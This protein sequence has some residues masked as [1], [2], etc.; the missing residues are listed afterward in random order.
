MTTFFTNRWKETVGG[1]HLKPYSWRRAIVDS[2]LKP[3]TKHT[4][5]TLSIYMNE[6]GQ[7]CFPGYELIAQQTGAA[8]STVIKHVGVAVAAGFLVKTQ[9]LRENGSNTSNEY[10]PAIP[11]D[12]FTVRQTDGGGVADGLGVVRETDPHNNPLSNNPLE[13]KPDVKKPSTIFDDFWHHFPKTRAGSKEK[14][15][16]ALYK[17][18]ERATTEEIM[19][20]VVAYKNS[21]EVARGFAKGGA[22]W[23]NDDRWASDYRIASGT[24]QTENP[25]MPA[26]MT[27][28]MTPEEIK[29]EKRRRAE[30][31]MG[32]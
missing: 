8:R 24:T 16:A 12:L 28:T 23:L 30:A 31:A 18:L 6:A 32:A 7:T 26:R 21:D 17:A 10:A 29:R 20:G 13:V 3:F 15:A 5:L 27:A 25:T 22:A 1:F 2:S 14:A 19:A 4:L 9:R 11:D